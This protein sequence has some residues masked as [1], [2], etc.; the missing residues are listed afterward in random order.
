M[1]RPRV[2]KFMKQSKPKISVDQ[3][4][5]LS[6]HKQGLW[7][8][9][10]RVPNPKTRL[11][12]TIRR[13]GLLQ[14]D[15][16][17]VVAR[18]QYLTML[19]RVGI[20]RPES[21]DALLYPD[22][23]LFEQVAHEACLLPKAD[24]DEFAPLVLSRRQVK[25]RRLDRLGPRPERVLHDVYSSI[26]QMGSLTSRDFPEKRVGKGTW[27]DWKPSKRALDILFEQGYLS[28]DCRRGFQRVY[29]VTERVMGRSWESS[30]R[31]L[32]DFYR[33]ATE[34]GLGALGVA[35]IREVADYYRIPVAEAAAATKSLVGDGIVLEVCVD[36]WP[37]PCFVRLK[38][39]RNL[40]SISKNSGPELTTLLSPFD[41]LIWDRRRTENVFGFRYRLGAYTPRD[42]R[43]DGYFVLPIL[44][45]GRLIGRVDPK[46]DRAKSVMILRGLQLEPHVS[47]T[48]DLVRAIA[49]ALSEFAEFHMCR[50][51]S[52]DSNYE[53]T[54]VRAILRH[55]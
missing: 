50:S 48:R 51:F 3:V 9:R 39:Y 38:D 4:R 47:K 45:R 43:T 53:P 16:I 14:I 37:E 29:D 21:L 25:H 46:A 44:Y 24:F 5:L 31:G 23:L 20:Y 22:R 11:L 13:L 35:S 10:E 55:L 30:R 34:K 8:Q 18:S 54:L 17:S 52:I 33:W 1:A 41:N 19:S 49:F 26:L 12:A 27:W 15:A 32:A 7:L 42:K 36:E 28:V 2:S 6:I 40:R